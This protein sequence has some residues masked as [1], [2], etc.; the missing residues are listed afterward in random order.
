MENILPKYTRPLKSKAD[1]VV[2]VSSWDKAVDAFDEK[3]Y[4][5]SVIAVINYIN[6]TLL[7]GKN[8]AENIEIVQMQG[9]AEIQINI[10]Q[11][12]FSIN[13]PFLRITPDTNQ[14]ALLRKIAEVNFSPMRLAQIVLVEDK[15]CFKY[16]MPLSVCQPNKVYDVLREV[17]IN[18][19]DYDNMFIDK[20]KASFYKKPNY[21]ELTTA[22]SDAVWAQISAVFDD[23]TNYTAFFKEKRWDGFIWDIIVISMLKIS[24]MPYVNGK[25]RSDLIE[26]IG[27]LFNG[28]VD[29]NFRVDK[30][31]NFMKKLVT[32]SREEI[33][34]NVYHAEQLTSLRWRSSAQII[35]DR[36]A[37]NLERVKKYEKEESYFNLSYYL[38]FTFLKL[39]YD[40]TLEEDYKNAIESILE[41]VS[42]LDPDD[43]APKLTKVFY[44]LQ[45]GTINKKETKEKKTGF[46]SKL[47]K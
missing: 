8:T 21:D 37:G 44:A 29:F 46:F 41:E 26:Y 36:L 7:E 13:A 31:T 33:M 20:Y 27:N 12:T 1:P 30:G 24:N 3:K 45:E 23:Y 10:T 40:Y 18:A 5:E 32:K 43:A 22:E 34:S 4:R 2:D 35:T 9:S 16:S 19:D 42:G 17:S 11:D 25:L 14:V 6:P 47:F 15:L 39:I 28:D 38:Q